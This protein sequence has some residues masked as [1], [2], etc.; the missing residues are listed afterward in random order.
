MQ[1]IIAL[2]HIMIFITLHKLIIGSII[3]TVS[4]ENNNYIAIKHEFR[5]FMAQIRGRLTC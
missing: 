2:Q 1:V 5:C 3:A 4:S